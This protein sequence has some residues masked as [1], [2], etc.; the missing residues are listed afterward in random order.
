M[1]DFLSVKRSTE[2]DFANLLDR[3]AAAWSE[4]DAQSATEC[5]AANAIYSAPPSP[6]VR[7]GRRELLEF[8]GGPGGRAAPMQLQWHH[9]A[10]N[11]RTQVGFGEYT[12]EHTDYRAHGVVVIRVKGG[13]VANW[14]EYEVESDRAW[15]DFNSPNDF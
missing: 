13:L 5:F 10:F 12:F 4:D 1:E 6:K 11:F 3:I 2:R 7:R 8:F 15:P 14:R 9:R